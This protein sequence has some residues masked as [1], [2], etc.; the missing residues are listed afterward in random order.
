VT[1]RAAQTILLVDDDRDTREMFRAALR[2]E[3]FAVRTA[4]DGIS[5][6]SQVQQH[7]PDVVVLDLDL[8]AVNG[9]DVHQEL[10]GHVD[11]RG[12]PVVI[13]TGTDWR[14]PVPAFATLR[15]PISPERLIAAVRKALS[16]A[17]SKTHSLA[18]I[19]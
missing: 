12:V 16:Q 3:G 18:N 5:A 19:P 7:I 9:L 6:L 2:M 10:A 14:S 17:P 15:K 1:K 4:V 13:V 8:P 11:T